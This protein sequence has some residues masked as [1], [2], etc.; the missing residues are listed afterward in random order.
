MVRFRARQFETVA[1]IDLFRSL[2]PKVFFFSNPIYLPHL[3]QMRS[4]FGVTEVMASEFK[5]EFG[6]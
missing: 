2:Q 6:W 5:S 4:P 3:T 1:L